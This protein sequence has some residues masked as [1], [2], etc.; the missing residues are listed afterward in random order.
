M[1]GIKF[2]HRRKEGGTKN[3]IGEEIS[4]HFSRRPTAAKAAW[5]NTIKGIPYKA[6]VRQL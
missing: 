3:K 1:T 5:P 2:E 4:C 6:A